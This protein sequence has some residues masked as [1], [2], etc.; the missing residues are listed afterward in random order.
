[1]RHILFGRDGTG[2]SDNH[3][4]LQVRTL[5]LVACVSMA[6]G[7]TE[8]WQLWGV[9]DASLGQARTVAANT[10]RSM[11]EQAETTFKTAETVVATLAE[12]V[13]SDGQG[14]EALT[15]FYQLMTSFAAALPAIHEMGILDAQGNAV[16]KARVLKPVGINYAERE[17]F[18]FHA[19]H[20]EG[21]VL[22]G[23]PV[24]SKLDG[25]RNIT[26]SR[27]VNRP[28]GGFGGVVVASVSMRFYQELFDQVQRKSG[29]IIALL[30]D[31]GAFLVRSPPRAA[32]ARGSVSLAP[33]MRRPGAVG[34]VAYTSMLDGVRR[35]GAYDHLSHYPIVAV[36]SQSS[37]D[38]LAGWRGEAGTHAV[39]LL[40]LVVVVSVLGRRVTQANRAVEAALADARA[41]QKAA[42]VANR[43][44]SDF[45]ANT[46]HE[47]RT[48]LNAIL[49][50]SEMMRDAILGPLDERYRSYAADIHGAGE[51][52]LHIISDILD[53]SKV[54]VGRLELNEES[55]DVAEVVASSAGMV[56][57]R[58]VHA[59][60]HIEI[61]LDGNL[62]LVRAD[63]LRLQQALLNLLS[64][65][66]KFTAKGGRVRI[67]AAAPEGQGCEI[68]VSDS[69]IGM[70]PEDI[71]VAL[72]PFRQVDSSH[73]RRFEG[74]GLGLPL[75]SKLIAL[76]G[77]ALAIE[78]ELGQGT[79]V[80]L[81][82][83]EGRV[84]RTSQAAAAWA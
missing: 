7:G 64:N 65:A 48:P 72:E 52:L 31:D 46:S 82:L 24:T 43:A 9:Y 78:S 6:L 58:A 23:A 80:R 74:T 79:T 3:P 11:A 66:V 47:L 41:G 54:E 28:G 26:V 37:W 40:G 50:F 32:D 10:A 68:R 76:H 53:L 8:A 14:P 69:G 4:S 1:M 34:M 36:V 45:L 75:S 13:E 61:A 15:R 81:T 63:R 59:G 18:R 35:L 16:V 5:A 56:R 42:E 67:E 33:E 30:S 84:V 44:K 77:G 39:V 60:I 29:G 27:R 55:I 19:S 25:S 49:G 21:G 17:Y 71:A 83:P 12:R 22:I 57:E 70:R 73:S 20:P 38:L 62:P 51:H 2:R